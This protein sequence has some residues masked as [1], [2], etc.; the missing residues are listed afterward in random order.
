MSYF[1]GF[2]PDYAHFIE[3]ENV[4]NQCAELRAEI[5]DGLVIEHQ[6]PVL[7]FMVTLNDVSFLAL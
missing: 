3:F 2:R 1:F 6:I 7:E 5:D 4:C